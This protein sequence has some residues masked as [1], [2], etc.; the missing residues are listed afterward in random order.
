VYSSGTVTVNSSVSIT[1]EK[2]AEFGRLFRSEDSH[3]MK[4]LIPNLA[5]PAIT[6]ALICL[7]LACGGGKSS[8]PTAPTA[9]ATRII[10]LEGSLAFGDVTVGQTK[11]LDITVRNTGTG[12]MSVTGVTAPTSVASMLSS[13]GSSSTVPAGGASTI[14]VRFTPSSVGTFSGTIT[15]TADQTSGTNTIQFS[16]SGIGAPIT[17]VGVV[18]DSSTRAALGGVRVSALTPSLLTTIASTTTDGNG[19]YSFV[20][21]SATS[22]NMNYTLN[23]YNIRNVSETFSGDSRRD[24]ALV[25]SAPC[26]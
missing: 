19:F 23:G 15:V 9:T 25:K 22:L 6:L 7:T 24:I 10:A 21:P 3:P 17:V 20:V 14:T 11:A 8:S 12:P 13:S 5:R 2:F 1:N 18:T 26:S 4:N 16:G